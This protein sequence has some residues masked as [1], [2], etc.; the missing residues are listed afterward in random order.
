MDKKIRLIVFNLALHASKNVDS[1]CCIIAYPA[2]VE[3]FD[4]KRVDIVPAVAS[5]SLY[6]DQFCIFQ[7]PQVLHYGAAVQ[8]AKVLAQLSGSPGLVP[9][10]VKN[11]AP[12]RIA[13][14]PEC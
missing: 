1:S 8:L 9:K 14:S 7:N 6:N 11:L 2:I 13:K 10:H 5:L 3:L 12:A 4:R